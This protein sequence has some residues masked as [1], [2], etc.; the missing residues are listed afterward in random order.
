MDEL[1]AG[2]GRA[3]LP[4]VVGNGVDALKLLAVYIKCEGVARIGCQDCGNAS[5]Q[6]QRNGIQVDV[7]VVHLI[8][9]NVEGREILE[10]RE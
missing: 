7:V 1:G 8:E 5:L 6:L 4:D 10:Q 9:W 3:R 2:D